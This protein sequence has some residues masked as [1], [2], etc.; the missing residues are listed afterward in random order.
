M[1]LF[2]GPQ[3][4]IFKLSQALLTSVDERPLYSPLLKFILLQ[5][6]PNPFNSQTRIDFAIASKSSVSLNIYSIF[7]ENIVTLTQGQKEAGNHFV[8]WNGKNSK[9]GDVSS[10]V[11]IIR[12]Q[13][14]QEV[15]IRK[16]LLIR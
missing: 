14:R 15:L 11:Y 9:G 2:A 4:V 6:Y 3:L 7:G 5:N 16:M 10:G 8:T 12:L 1:S 13:V